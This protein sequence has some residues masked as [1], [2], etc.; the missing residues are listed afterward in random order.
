MAQ[1]LVY[2]LILGWFRWVADSTILTIFLHGLI[3][4]EGMLETFIAING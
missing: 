4:L 2:G 1:V 3:N